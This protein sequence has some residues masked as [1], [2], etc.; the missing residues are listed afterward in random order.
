MILLVVN[1]RKDKKDT[2]LLVVMPEAY[3]RNQVLSAIHLEHLSNENDT[4]I[5]VTIQH[6]AVVDGGILKAYSIDPMD[7]FFP[8]E[9]HGMY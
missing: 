5:E 2:P 3:T 1:V 7:A 9:W 8:D 6:L 4:D